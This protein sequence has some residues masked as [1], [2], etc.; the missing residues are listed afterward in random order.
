M[1]IFYGVACLLSIILLFIYFFVDKKR[2]KWLMLLFISVVVCNTGYFMLSLSSNLTFALISNSIAYVGNVFLPFFMLMLILD[3]CNIKYSKALTYTLLAVGVVMLFITTSG[4][5]L[6]I[7]YKEVAL[8]IVDGGARLVKE[9]GV[10]H[11]LYFVYLFG[12]MTSMVTI[13]IYSIVKK[14][15]TSNMHAIFLSVIVFGNILVWFVEQ[16]VEHNFEFL[17]ISYIINEGLLLLLYGMLRE[18]EYIKL[19]KLKENTT[20]SVD[21]SVLDLKNNLNKEEIAL[22]FTN[23][24]ALKN[25]T[26]REKE[27]LKHILLGERRKEIAV[28]LYISESAVRK[29][30]TNIFRKLDVENRTELCKKAKGKI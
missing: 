4:G 22:V 23:W 2:E 26:N 13:I 16:F 28:N 11:N 8:E 19:K 18:Y 27:I 25:L 24:K 6:P 10:L 1:T 14:K 17:C 7:Y 15:I 30:T 5:Y 12:Y 3:V 29:H 20:S 21:L 9:Y